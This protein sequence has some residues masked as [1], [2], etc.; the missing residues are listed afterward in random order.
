MKDQ[1]IKIFK[2]NLQSQLIRLF[3]IPPVCRRSHPDY[4]SLG[5]GD[6]NWWGQSIYFDVSCLISLLPWGIHDFLDWVE[7]FYS[8]SFMFVGRT[9]EK[10][11][12]KVFGLMCI[13]SFA[14]TH[15]RAAQCADLVRK[16]LPRIIAARHIATSPNPEKKRIKDLGN[17]NLLSGIGS[18]IGYQVLEIRY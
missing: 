5:V 8:K 10:D 18:S 7:I 9:K 14:R 15:A 2:N 1:F 12:K 17:K 11:L 13:N 3:V 4:S 6:N 16:P